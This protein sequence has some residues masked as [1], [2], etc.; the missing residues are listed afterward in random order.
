MN[1]QRCTHGNS[2][3]PTLPRSRLPPRVL[4][5]ARPLSCSPVFEFP[6]LLSYRAPPTGC[7]SKIS[8]NTLA[9]NGNENKN[10]HALESLKAKLVAD[11]SNFFPFPHISHSVVL[12]FKDSRRPLQHID[13]APH[14]TLIPLNLADLR[15]GLP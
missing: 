6:S 10:F 2:R 4:C 9:A 3:C 7:T 13:A 12:L 1:R 5:S 14:P 8:S 15:R 11:A